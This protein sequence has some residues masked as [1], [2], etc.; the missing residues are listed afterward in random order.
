MKKA[1]KKI[2]WHRCEPGW[3]DAITGKRH[4]GWSVAR[5]CRVRRVN[6]SLR[7]YQCGWYVFNDAINKMIGPFKTPEAAMRACPLSIG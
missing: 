5:Q 2:I 4:A 7:Q 1:V 6:G 3:W